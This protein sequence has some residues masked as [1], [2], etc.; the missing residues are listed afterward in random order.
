MT[1][2]IPVPKVK[3][4]RTLSRKTKI[5]VSLGP[6]SEN[7]SMI[8]NMIKA[9]ADIFRL[10]FSHG[11]LQEKEEAIKMIRKA[12]EITGKHV[13]IIAD[14]QGPTIRLGDVEKFYVH[15][16][17]IVYLV[18]K[19]KGDAKN[20]EIPLPKKEVFE[21]IDE[22]DTLLIDDGKVVLKVRKV[23][24]D[25][26]VS[27][28]LIDG[29]IRS[30][31]TFVVREK[32]PKIDPLSE[33]DIQDIEFSVKKGVDFFALSF[34]RTAEDM[35]KLRRVVNEFGGEDIKLIAKI[36]TLLGVKNI[37]SILDA[38]DAIMIARGDLGMYFPLE[39]IP[40]VQAFLAKKCLE[41]GKP[42]I[43]ATQI[44]ESMIRNPEPTRAE[45]ADVY[46]AIREGISALMLSTETAIG[47]YPLEA[48]IWLDR[49]IRAAEKY[50][51]TPKPEAKRQEPIYDEFA[52]GIT[53]LAES[54]KGAIV[55]YTE[56]GFTALRIS[57]YRPRVPVFAATN[58]I[59][60]ARQISLLWGITPV[61]V[62]TKNIDEA[63][64]MVMEMLKRLQIVEKGD[65]LILT[66]GVRAGV[67]DLGKIEIIE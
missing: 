22:G 43:L 54:I 64:S 38:S 7:L 6:A 27:E 8:T 49:I 10:N 26:I 17:E 19:E 39:D 51:K 55:M 18:N 52:R 23:L 20:K 25:K 35:I 1:F 67:T 2:H 24:D 60:T 53:A 28:V 34:V 15:K 59:R 42:S 40:R 36:E 3:L 5:I 37:D 58:S 29:E 66:S 50:I 32:N 63:L 31:I 62:D 47:N 61:L 4:P 33:K 48:V 13:G 56:K 65:V 30:R 45:A 41:S 14:L 11:N 46:T 57:K 9:G 21:V 44:L 16:G 12:E